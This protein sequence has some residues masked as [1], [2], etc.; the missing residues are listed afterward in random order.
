MIGHTLLIANR[1]EIASRIIRTGRA[2]GLTTV[3]VYSEAD[4]GAPFTRE[5]DHAYAIGPAS[6]VE[7]YLNQDRILAVAHQAGAYHGDAFS[8][9]HF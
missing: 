1:G 7:S 9:S 5:A 6:A 8:S 2:M 3:A 4:K